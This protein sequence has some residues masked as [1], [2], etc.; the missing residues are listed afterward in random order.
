[1]ADRRDSRQQGHIQCFFDPEIG[2]GAIY[3]VGVEI[4]IV[5]IRNTFQQKRRCIKACKARRL[6][7]FG[8]VGRLVSRLL[9]YAV[10]TLSSASL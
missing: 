1:L 2:H 3:Q 7:S 8:L 5:E 9:V 6:L 10:V 4:Q